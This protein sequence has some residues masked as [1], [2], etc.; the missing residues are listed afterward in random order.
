MVEKSAILMGHLKAEWLDKLSADMMVAQLAEKMA[1]PRE[2][3]PVD[4]LGRRLAVLWAD[5]LG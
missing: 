2:I 3:P 1:F 4:L 5:Y